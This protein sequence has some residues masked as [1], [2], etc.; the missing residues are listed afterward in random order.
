MLM[1]QA[2]SGLVSTIKYIKVPT[3][4]LSGKISFFPLKAQELIL[5]CSFLQQTFEETILFK[6]YSLISK[7]VD[8]NTEELS[9]C[10]DCDLESLLKYFMNCSDYCK[11][12]AAT[13]PSSTYKQTINF[14][15]GLSLIYKHGSALFLLNQIL[16]KRLQNS[17]YNI[18]KPA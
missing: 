9:C 16:T 17:Y 12:V 5:V 3:A 4:S 8:F 10:F 11:S 14:A 6:L 2:K 15:T 1:Q 13:N 18:D 7:I